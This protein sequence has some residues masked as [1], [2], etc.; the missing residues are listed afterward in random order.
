MVTISH[1]RDVPMLAQTPTVPPDA[2]H[3]KHKAKSVVQDAV[4]RR[5][6]IL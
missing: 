1:S 6:R 3:K 2:K 4:N 5:R